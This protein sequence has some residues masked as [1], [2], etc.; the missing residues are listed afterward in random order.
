MAVWRKGQ[1]EHA[2]RH[3]QEKKEANET[4]KTVIVQGSLESLKR[5]QL[6]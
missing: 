3:R 6:A 5:Q 2:A 1:K 4:R